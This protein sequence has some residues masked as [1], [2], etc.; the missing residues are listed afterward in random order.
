MRYLIIVLILSIVNSPIAEAKE[1]KYSR[2]IILKALH[3][4]AEE[5]DVPFRLLYAICTVESALKPKALH[6]QD[7]DGNSYGLCQI[8]LVTAQDMGFASNAR[9]LF[10]PYVNSYYAAKYLKFQMNRYEDDWVRAIAAYNKGS[11]H[12]RISNAEYV[13]KVM[14]KAIDF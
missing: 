5:A 1:K 14:D 3:Q 10:D 7:G 11:S 13:K 6:R 9:I 12:F 4:A 8:K 2:P